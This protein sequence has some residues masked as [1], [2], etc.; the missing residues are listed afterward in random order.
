MKINFHLIKKIIVELISVTFYGTQITVLL[1]EYDF[2]QSDKC[3]N[4]ELHEELL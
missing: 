3:I 1:V 4:P 2:I